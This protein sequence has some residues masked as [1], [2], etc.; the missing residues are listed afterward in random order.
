MTKREGDAINELPAGQVV[1][2]GAAVVQLDELVIHISGKRIKHNL[3]DDDIMFQGRGIATPRRYIT[4]RFQNVCPIWVTSK[5]DPVCLRSEPDDVDDFLFV[6][7]PQIE[8]LAI[9]IECEVQ[10]EFVQGDETATLNQSSGW[11]DITSQ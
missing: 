6:W 4:Q 11:K 3:V 10:D 5:R 9:A 7:R 1:G 8:R 2:V